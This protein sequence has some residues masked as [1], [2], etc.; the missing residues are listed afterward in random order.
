MIQIKRNNANL[1]AVDNPLSSSNYSKAVMGE[2][3]ITLVWEQ[4]TFL[5]LN[6]G[7][8]IVYEGSNFTMNQIPTVKKLSSR[9]YQYNAVFQSTKYEL[10]K[11][12]YMLTVPFQG[13]EQSGGVQ[14][15]FPLTGTA[16]TFMQLLIDNLNR[17]AGAATWSL[18][19][20]IPG[21]EYKNLTFSDE[22]CLTVLGRL[23]DE[24]ATEYHVINH[25]IHLKK[26]STDREITLQ[27]GSTLYDIERSSVNSSDIV[28]RLYA[29]G[30]SKN[31]A[32]NY[33]GGSTK[34]LLPAPDTYLQHANA[35][36]YGIIEQSKTFED[37]YPRL[38][39]GAAG[40]VTSVGNEFTFT[41]SHLDFNV[42]DCLL[43]G[44]K[45]KVRFNTGEC[46]GYDFEI[47]S[48]NN[49]T[50]TY[51]I[52]ANTGEKD[53]TLPTTDLKPAIGDK[54]I[55]IDL[56][57]PANYV[58]SGELEVKDKGLEYLN[59]NATPKVNYKATFSAVYAKQHVQNIECG[60]TVP[61]VDTNIGINERLRI[62]KITKG[63]TDFYN[64]QF[65]LSNTVTKTALQRI[66]GDVA[67]VTNQV[68]VTNDRVNKN[69]IQAYQNTRE[70]KD[71]VFDPDGYFDP[72]NIKPASIE[73]GML[74]VGT[75]S[76]SFQLA[77]TLQPNYLNN[78]Q[79]ITWS[80]GTLAHFTLVDD[81]IK[82]WVI[83]EGNL[84]IATQYAN[85]AM[86]IYARCS[87]TGT[88]GDIY[89]STTATKFDADGTNWMFL[90]GLLHT[91]IN[92]VR[93]ISLSYGE[94][95][96]NGANIKTG[97]ISGSGLEINLVTGIIK[98][99]VQF[100]SGETYKEVGAGIADAKSE[101]VQLAYNDATT[102]SNTAKD[103]A[104]NTAAT[105]ATNKANA[106]YLEAKNYA[107]AVGADKQAQIDGQ[108]ISWFRQV[109]ALLTNSPASDWTTEILRNQ[110]ANDTYTNTSNG[111]CWRFQYNGS[112]SQWEWG[113]IADTATQQALTAA[114]TATAI[115]NGKRTVF[116]SQPTT[117]Y[118]AA[119]LWLNNGDLY[120]CV[121]A[122]SSGA[123]VLGDWTKAVKYTDD[124]AVNDLQIG[125][126]NLVL[127]SLATYTGIGQMHIYTLS[128]PL[129]VGQKYA[130]SIKGDVG[131][132]ANFGVWCNQ[133]QN[134]ILHVESTG[135][136]KGG[137][138]YI[139]GNSPTLIGVYSE[140][141][142][143]P[144][145]VYWIKIEK[146]DKTTDFT[147]AD[148]DVANDATI[149]ANAAQA[150]AIST[151]AIAAQAKADLAELNA[152][153]HADGIVTAEEQRAINDA[154]TKA[155][156]AQTAAINAA[157]ID[158]TA[159][160]NLAYANS[161]SYINSIKADLQSQIDGNITSWFYDY[162]PS[163]SN[164]PASNW[165]P[166]SVRDIHLGDLF[167]WTSKGWAYRYQKISG[168]Y[169]WTKISDTDVT[170]ALNDAATAQ[171]IANGKRTTFS[172]QPTTPYLVSDL[173]L[174]NGDLYSCVTARSSGGFVATDWT[175]AVKYTDDTAVNNL[176]ISSRNIVK[177]SGIQHSGIGMLST[178]DLAKPLVVGKTYTVSIK[179]N[180][181]SGASF[182]VWYDLN[183][184][185]LMNVPFGV[186]ETNQTF[187][188]GNISDLNRISVYSEV[189]SNPSTVYWIAIVE[190]NKPMID[191]QEAPEDDYVKKAIKGSASIN[192]GLV[193]G[194]VMAVTDENG[195]V[196]AGMNGLASSNVSIWHGG[197]SQQAIDSENNPS[198]VAGVDRK[199][200]S[201]HRAFG[202]I[203]WDKFGSTKIGQFLIKGGALV[204]YF[205]LEERVRLHVNA[206]ST[207]SDLVNT[208][209]IRDLTD[210]A[211]TDAIAGD[212]WNFGWNP[213][214]SELNQNTSVSYNIV[215]SITI[216]ADT[217]IKLYSGLAGASAEV[218]SGSVSNLVVSESFQIEGKGV[219]TPSSQ[220]TQ[221]S[222]AAGTYGITYTISVG[223]SVA[224]NSYG[225]IIVSN[226][227]AYITTQEVLPSRTE[228]GR[229]GI[230]SYF[231]IANFF[232][233]SQ[234][235]GWVMKG[236]TDIPG[237][238]ATGSVNS[239]GGLSNEWGAKKRAS[240]VWVTKGG[241]G[242]YNVPHQAGST[243]SVQ[244]TSTTDN[245][246]ARVTSRGTNT[247]Q[248]TVRNM[249]G[250]AVDTGSFDFTLYG[251]N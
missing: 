10:S 23:A 193:L 106:V 128:E 195:N 97:V 118:L 197:N 149:K 251:A 238:L 159:K 161:Q 76:Q 9:L 124:T 146:G 49:A 182:N 241:T 13:D 14:S 140:Q 200:G 203:L 59:A 40:T 71:M 58:T 12:M 242:I 101:A 72:Q 129:V 21:T 184:T 212:V 202:K 85:S 115:A 153:A 227:G 218:N 240:S 15:E 176:K 213:E 172:V 81:Q 137:F 84:T 92:G 75:K 125:G 194:N 133:D 55:L 175:K 93:G 168:V 232:H 132:G 135:I 4:P 36:L 29:F 90:I 57:M 177:N 243:Y 131:A 35:T 165:S 39:S 211:T 108:I 51:V 224:I 189:S 60:D 80:A 216:P 139:Q 91:P 110:H 228:V 130:I 44:T 151:S 206:I 45:A 239:S 192:G 38:S 196:M 144:S 105:D 82:E 87:R 69:R 123:F 89:F 121:T 5:Q 179:A 236:N 2:E 138:Y 18:G 223:A 68:V 56:V 215:G 214:H 46:A 112:T 33:R 220:G 154:T 219:Y 43:D 229:D 17:V 66:A 37:I 160:S 186:S 94:T 65:D 207:L 142:S 78:P 233:F 109:D 187:V 88:T 62:V 170:K 209:W 169:S 79:V 167:Y 7:D 8:Y 180:V 225:T 122:R 198:A 73:T 24:F 250:T 48:Y 230:F 53:F 120:K 210:Y 150:A 114:G 248:V 147:I 104:I 178:Y 30:S 99:Q 16:E 41:D 117:P 42:N 183:N 166:D 11:A 31:I 162:E 171:T 77:C 107:D 226:E 157:A 246:N 245:L 174:N 116:D 74:S 247:F 143:N 199:D 119:D 201:G 205:G 96:I 190:G 136:A 47:A 126:K 28:T 83:S 191:W 32:A 145:T 244:I 249:S 188:C 54:Y 231:G 25:T 158:A 20:V 50:K 113:V 204:G 127:N 134:R 155:N 26:I 148:E 61:V 34:L 95:T 6:I 103:T 152:K 234:L 64:V 52:I 19:D 111:K 208:A 164:V 217:N 86:Y 27:Y 67:N 22:D 98:G 141:S 221:I 100:K 173:W 156:N 3:Q 63:L 163:V 1:L 222:I 102:K 237:V 70:L 235:G 181:G 185:N